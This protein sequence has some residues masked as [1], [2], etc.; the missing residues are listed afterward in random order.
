MPQM[1]LA[2]KLK[3]TPMNQAYSS[4]LLFNGNLFNA[5]RKNACTKPVTGKLIRVE[6]KNFR[7]LLNQIVS[8]WKQILMMVEIFTALVDTV[9]PTAYQIV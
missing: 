6:Q 5:Y 8:E 4:L 9:L 1:K 7:F 2:T 3:L